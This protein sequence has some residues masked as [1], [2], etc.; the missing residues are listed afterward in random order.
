M[1]GRW[2]APE[3][4]GITQ[5]MRCLQLF[6]YLVTADI[7]GIVVSDTVFWQPAPGPEKLPLHLFYIITYTTN[8][9]E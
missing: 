1:A 2:F 3:E 5:S 6:S 7:C 9:E 8:I 4:A